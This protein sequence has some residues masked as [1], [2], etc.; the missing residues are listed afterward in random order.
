[1][2]KCIFSLFMIPLGVLSQTT[3]E[4]PFTLKGFVDVY[5]AYDFSH[6]ENHIRQPFLYNHN[7]H[8][9]FNLNL[10]LLRVAHSEGRFRTNLAFQA[11]T[12]AQDNY[13]AE[14]N[15][16]KHIFEANVGVSLNKTQT[17]WLDAGIFPSHI[18]FESAISSDN[19][20]LTR[21]LLAE[22]SPYYLSGV[23][24][25]GEVSNYLTITALVING[26]QK[27]ARNPGN[28][29]PSFGTQFLFHPGEKFQLNWSTY[30]GNEQPDSAVLF[31]FFNNFYA[32]WKPVNRWE[33]IAGF[34]IGIQQN[35]TNKSFDKVWYS[36]VLIARVHLAEKTYLA[37]RW[38]YYSDKKGV[39]INYGA[40]SFFQT[41]GVS[42]N[43]DWKLTEK[44]MFRI[45]G[46][47]L[48]SP[49]ETFPK[50]TSFTRRNFVI[51]NSLA[52]K[53]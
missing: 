7:R 50:Q 21:S 45:E 34:D 42:L 17:L 32:K 48:F 53:F 36:P 31:R 24:L 23:K 33:M 5:Y 52:A 6:P 37:G 43:L 8:N 39:I 49:V 51:V 2:K 27:I 18:G 47:H 13:S 16:L 44:V 40:P 28:Q 4:S 30:L 46:R 22:N 25:T 38:E 26:W 41:G 11:G 35:E 1:M 10:A 19:L 12:Y 3:E 15:L 14:E 9:E 29:T 20:T